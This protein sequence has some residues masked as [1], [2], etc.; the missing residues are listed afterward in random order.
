MIKYYFPQN[1]LVLE[2]IINIYR[3]MYS[4]VANGKAMYRY[5][6]EMHIEDQKCVANG[7]DMYRLVMEMHIEEH[8]I[9]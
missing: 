8:E 2:S 1:I 6:M 9:L 4:G 7:K 5:V 3:C